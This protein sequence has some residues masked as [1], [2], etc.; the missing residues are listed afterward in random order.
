MCWIQS[1]SCARRAHF[2]FR[3]LAIDYAPPPFLKKH[4]PSP[5]PENK[6]QQRSLKGRF[7]AGTVSSSG[8][9]GG[10]ARG[11]PFFSPVTPPRS[12]RC[13]SSPFTSC[14]V[15]LSSTSKSS[16]SSLVSS[17]PFLLPTAHTSLTL[18]ARIL[19][20]TPPLPPLSR[21]T[22]FRMKS[23]E[24]K[25]HSFTVPSS[26][27]VITKFLLNCRHVTALWCL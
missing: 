10:A 6:S 23:P 18:E 7:M 20:T 8:S 15:H 26:E 11:S 19:H 16:T 22:R 17:V 13:S 14:P 12:P 27:L 2:L 9:S 24:R 25:S 21:L 4:N 3:L 5:P 1:W